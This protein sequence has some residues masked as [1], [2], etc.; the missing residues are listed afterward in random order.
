MLLVLGY[1]VLVSLLV[2]QSRHTQ[3]NSA[4]N[5]PDTQLPTSQTAAEPTPP[6]RPAAAVPPVLQWNQIESPD[7]R[8]Y[9]ANLRGIGCPEQTIRDII[10][11]DVDEVYLRRR[12]EVDREI[13]A[14]N[15]LTATAAGR[16]QASSPVRDAALAS[17]REEQN[18]VLAALLGPSS[19]EVE[20]AAPDKPAPRVRALD[21]TISIPLAFQQA[22]P[23]AVALDERQIAII[24]ELRQK[25]RDDLAESSR[26]PADPAY[27]KRWQEAQRESDDLMS[28]LL[29]GQFFLDF[30][31]QASRPAKTQQ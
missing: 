27:R 28:G 8:T 22:D 15:R 6:A 18:S 20:A 2:R 16:M 1:I 31:I 5:M 19:K 21:R 29:G 11:A 3:V 26:N 13:S 7:Y 25:F 12:L 24:D 9:V 23:A 17:L 10:M 14:T 30:Q 4:P